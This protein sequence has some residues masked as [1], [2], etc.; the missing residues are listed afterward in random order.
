MNE[1]PFYDRNKLYE[2]VWA[3][4]VD[5]VAKRY[6]VPGVALAKT[7]RKLKVPLPGRGHWAKHKVGKAPKRPPL[8]SM[9]APPRIYRQGGSEKQPN[10]EETP[11]EPQRL[12]PDVFREGKGSGRR[13]PR[14]GTITC[15]TRTRP[16]LGC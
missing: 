14:S 8:P 2:E 13:S 9:K 12:R 7:C 11:E 6:G 15:R 10:Q 16:S 5:K 3:E 1:S 4:A